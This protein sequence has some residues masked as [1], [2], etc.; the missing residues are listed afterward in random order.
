MLEIVDLNTLSKICI[1]DV[2]SPFQ[3]R[4]ERAWYVMGTLDSGKDV[5]DTVYV[6]SVGKIYSKCGLNFLEVG[7][8]DDSESFILEYFECVHDVIPSYLFQEFLRKKVSESSI[9]EISVCAHDQDKVLLV[10]LNPYHLII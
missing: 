4:R 10:L 8:L 5:L 6:S 7:I 2:N 3:L 1:Q 9:V